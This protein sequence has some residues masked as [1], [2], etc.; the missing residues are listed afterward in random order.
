MSHAHR[1][2]LV[3]RLG[4][5]PRLVGVVVRIEATPGGWARLETLR[6][7][8]LRLRASGKRVVA[9]LSSPSMREYLV[10]TAAD[11]IIMDESGPLGLTGIAAQASFFGAALEKLGARFEVA[12][13]GAYKSF[14]ET[15]SRADMSPA[16]REAHDAI[17]DGLDAEARRMLASGRAVD[18]GR[19]AALLTGGP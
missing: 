2:G 11:T 13:R 7:I 9:H 1:D 18:P 19:A 16:H 4:R 14:A 15:F 10:A 12:Y 3:T 6:T 17:L 8:L 5:D